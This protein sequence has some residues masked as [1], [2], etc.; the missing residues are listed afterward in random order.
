M[1]V[2]LIIGFVAAIATP[3]FV[4]SM[5]GQRLRQATRS[6]V[7]VGKY[8]R[9]MAVAGQRSMKLVFAVGGNRLAIEEGPVPKTGAAPIDTRNQVAGLTNESA[10]DIPSIIPAPPLPEPTE[11]EPGP[12]L[13]LSRQ[14]EGVT[15]VRVALRDGLAEEEKGNATILYKSNGTCTPYEVTLRDEDERDVVITV[16]FLGEATHEEL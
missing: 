8:A 15:I 13:I 14:F 10:L 7:A 4:N 6:V 5:K 16:D 1:L 3:S 12:T 9:T 2:V 11:P